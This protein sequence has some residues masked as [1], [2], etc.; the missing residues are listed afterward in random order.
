MT[1]IIY[2]NEN[3]CQ[4]CYKCVR[5]CPV[6]AISIIDYHA[7]IDDERCILC[8]KCISVCPVGAQKYRNDEEKVTQL[9]L[10]EKKVILSVAPSF[11][12]E[13]DM[14]TGNLVAIAQKMG[15]YGVSET[16]LGAQLVTWAQREQL[17]NSDKPVFST[18]CPTFVHLVLKYFPHL[19]ENLSPLASPL[20]AQCVML[21]EIYGE[22]IGIVFVGPC[23]GKKSEADNNPN[24]LDAAITFDEFK[25]IVK[26]AALDFETEKNT[27]YEYKK[28]IPPHSNGGAIYPL[29]GGMIETI[30]KLAPSSVADTGFFH[31]AGTPAIKKM[32][33]S[34][35]FCISQNVFCE[36]LACDGGCINGSA[37]FDD[38]P[39]LTKKNKV[40]KYY[41]LLDK[42]SEDEFIK[43]YAPKALSTN[44]LN[45][46]YNF[47][48]PVKTMEF[49]TEDKEK[50]WHQLGKY[51]EKDF[52]D[53]GACGYDTCDN[54]AVACL[55]NRAELDMCA[56]CMKKQAQNKVK[57]FMKETPLALCVVDSNLKIVE[58]NYKFIE[59]SVDIDID[60]N[61]DL[62]QKVIGGEIERF[63]PLANLIKSAFRAKERNSSI[64]HQEGK[65][66]DVLAFPFENE[67]HAGLIIQ[68]ITKPSMKREVIVEKAQKVIRNHLTSVQKIAFLLGE[69]AAETE[70]TLNEIIDAYKSKEES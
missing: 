61:D 50:I 48:E 65:I 38:E 70:I 3:D 16:A 22:N 39:I 9:L 12:G 25:S 54:F 46:D 26:N 58:C 44:P 6:K 24:L 28:F 11:A 69:T 53:C 64:I 18:A 57:A 68:D 67:S 23:L 37:I 59:L 2:T 20:L 17:N 8:G 62:I 27:N 1:S 42:Y 32:L 47:C 51:E 29:D 49:S 63:F 40:S 56:T 35:D 10:S 15:F 66:F 43:K 13:F 41:K 4:D 34:E 14:A 30:K 7:S 19:K 31:Y 60:I 45:T 52:I 33:E 55:E 5:N 36:F 21:R